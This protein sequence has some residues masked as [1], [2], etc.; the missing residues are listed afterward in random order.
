MSALYCSTETSHVA[1]GTLRVVV[2]GTSPGSGVPAGEQPVL[3]I[4]VTVREGVTDSPSLT[5][6]GI[7]L[8]DPQAQRV[9]VVLSETTVAVS[10]E[11][12]AQP[13]SFS[14]NE[15]VPNPFNPSTTIAYDVPQQ[16]HI[17]LII[18]N[19]LGQEVAWIVDTMQ[20]PGRYTVTW[21]GTNSQGIGVASG[22]Y[23]YRL[24]SNT[25]YS[26]TKRMILL[27]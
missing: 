20:S 26:R 27:K 19:M 13:T 10:K 7:I 5:L 11:E 8:A 6:S 17:T 2:Y 24:T 14:L 25:G 9:P 12:I 23:M 4:P 16:A 1:G 22:V 21:H 18:Y 15:A 3:H